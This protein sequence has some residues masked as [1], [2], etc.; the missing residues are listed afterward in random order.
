M[1]LAKEAMIHH[2]LKHH[3]SVSFR[4]SKTKSHTVKLKK[5]SLATWCCHHVHH[6]LPESNRQLNMPWS[7]LPEYWASVHHLQEPHR[8]ALVALIDIGASVHAASDIQ[9]LLQ[10][11][12]HMIQWEKSHR[13]K[14]ALVLR[15]HSQNVLA[16]VGSSP[17]KR[18]S[19]HALAAHQQISQWNGYPQDTNEANVHQTRFLRPKPFQRE[20][21]H[22]LHY[23]WN[24]GGSRMLQKGAWNKG[25]HI[26]RCNCHES[27]S[28]TC[29]QSKIV[30]CT[31]PKYNG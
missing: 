16:I 19:S 25:I 24:F 3:K 5:A 31:W 18:T 28:G 23:A 6:V 4:A 20:N 17:L 27:K 1:I 26:P 13:S 12:H 10:S 21:K 7:K 2:S 29:S 14:L 9:W 11:D 15:T 22:H 8:L 30:I